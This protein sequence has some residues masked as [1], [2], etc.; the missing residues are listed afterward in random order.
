A[1]LAGVPKPV[2]SEARR[3]LHELERRDHAARPAAPQQELDL[4]A[5][6]D[7]A[8]AA[9]LAE[10]DELDPDALSPRDALDLL[11]RLKETLRN[12]R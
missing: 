9:A 6:V 10:L 3:Y 1:R 7:P 11:F 4:P 2:V 5:P 8:E 12:R